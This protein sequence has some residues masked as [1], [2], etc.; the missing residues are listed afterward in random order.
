MT[1]HAETLISPAAAASR[2]ARVQQKVR[3]PGGIEAWLVEDYAI[4]LI[5]M[6]F[7]FRGGA[8]QDPPSQARRLDDARR[9]ARRGRGSA[10]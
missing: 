1:G 9:L 2:A 6:N 4:P 5:A 7:A 10:R 8:A 3:S